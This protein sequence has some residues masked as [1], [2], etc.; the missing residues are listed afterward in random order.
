MDYNTCYPPMAGDYYFPRDSFMKISNHNGLQR[1][2]LEQI[3]EHNQK[4]CDIARWATA[5]TIATDEAFATYD[6]QPQVPSFQGF[7]Q[8]GAPVPTQVQPQ[9][10]WEICSS[11]LSISEADGGG[12]AYQEWDSHYSQESSPYKRPRLMHPEMEEAGETHA[13][14]SLN[15]L[16]P[17]SMSYVMAAPPTEDTRINYSDLVHNAEMQG[18]WAELHDFMA[19]PEAPETPETLC[20]D[21]DGHLIV[22][23]VGYPW[24]P[25]GIKTD[26]GASYIGEDEPRVRYRII[27]D[28]RYRGQQSFFI[29]YDKLCGFALSDGPSVFNEEDELQNVNS[30]D[31]F[32]TDMT[33]PIWDSANDMSWDNSSHQ[34][35]NDACPIPLRYDTGTDF[36]PTKPR[37]QNPMTPTNWLHE[38]AKDLLRELREFPVPDMEDLISVIPKLKAVHEE[39]L[40]IKFAKSTKQVDLAGRRGKSVDPV[41]ILE[42]KCP[43]V[44]LV[45]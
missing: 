26:E 9:F 10:H 3:R 45:R 11:N 42:Y 17:E 30:E 25:M 44:V 27:T 33:Y 39:L 28:G 6:D 38:T 19:E 20:Y 34:T 4:I 8:Q 22:D 36:F 18:C 14:H 43:N 41:A 35:Q 29:T 5:V 12:Q 32:F 37:P 31:K 7:V 16:F 13:K 23:E 15:E 1:V 2:A 21:S 40:N 24:Q